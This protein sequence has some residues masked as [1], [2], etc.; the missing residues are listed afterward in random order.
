MRSLS[1]AVIVMFCLGAVSACSGTKTAPAGRWE[2][3]YEASDAMVVVRLEI[4]PKGDI[5]LSAPDALNIEAVPDDQRPAM[6][7]RLAD[8]L[9][10]SWG[11]AVPRQFDFDGRV[12]R[13]PGGVAPQ[14]EWN[15]DTKQMTV[16]VYPGL[17]PSIR[18]SMHPVADFSNNPWAN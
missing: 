11:D 7:Q 10:V 9:Q 3:T 15:P 2:G 8:G 5:Y 4:T 6:R 14:M 17:H 1:A 12:F 13:K 18:I 16:I